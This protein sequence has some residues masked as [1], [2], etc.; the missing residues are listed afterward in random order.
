MNINAIPSNRTMTA[1]N[2]FASQYLPVQGAEA[3]N[4]VFNR[5]SLSLGNVDSQYKTY[6]V[7]TTQLKHYPWEYRPFGSVA[8]V[9]M[10]QLLLAFLG[11]YTF[12]PDNLEKPTWEGSESQ[13]DFLQSFHERILK[14]MQSDESITDGQ[15]QTESKKELTDDEKINAIIAKYTQEPIGHEAFRELMQDLI[16]TRL[17]TRDEHRFLRLAG[18][19]GILAEESRLYQEFMD[20]VHE[21][22][23]KNI[24]IPDLYDLFMEELEKRD[25]QLSNMQKFAV[26]KDKDKRS[27]LFHEMNEP[28]SKA[29]H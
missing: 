19:M 3:T 5:D 26:E 9:N 6:S 23:G 27:D 24:S 10:S 29:S 13:R 4:P 1:V 7:Q 11:D 15:G 12:Y 14:V 18:T 28:I 22:E 21:N 8:R 20:F 16:D 25:E 2:P 17:F